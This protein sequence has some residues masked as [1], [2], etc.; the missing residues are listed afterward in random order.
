MR[1]PRW[2]PEVP[3]PW[4]PAYHESWR[5]MTTAEKQWTFFVDLMVIAICV[6]LIFLG[7]AK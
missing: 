5:A 2:F 3:R 7:A 6:A 4:N 1:L